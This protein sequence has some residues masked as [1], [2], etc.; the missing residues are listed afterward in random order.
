MQ[1][2]S[3][4]KLIQLKEKTFLNF[5]A[6]RYYITTSQ[7]D[8][9]FIQKVAVK[10]QIDQEKIKEIF[11]LF[12]HLN[13]VMEVSDDALINLHKKIEYFYKNCR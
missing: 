1:Q 3:H 6:E 11:N 4:S 13:K 9:A 5:I 7:V 2:G 8:M 12:I 10:S